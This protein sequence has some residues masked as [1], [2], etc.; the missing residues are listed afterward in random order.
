[1][2]IGAAKDTMFA[3]THSGICVAFS[4][5][6][7]ISPVVLRPCYWMYC[8]QLFFETYNLVLDVLD[9]NKKIRFLNISA[10][11]VI[12]SLFYNK[13]NDSLMTVSQLQLLEV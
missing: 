11:E 2:E 12:R 6:T 5:G 3:L 10:D 9:T 13:N 7:K 4:Q 1:V 8:C